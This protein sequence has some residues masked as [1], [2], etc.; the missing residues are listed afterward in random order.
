MFKCDGRYIGTPKDCGS[1]YRRMNKVFDETIEDIGAERI[2][3]KLFE[4]R[5]N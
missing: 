1:L 5:R 2:E 4:A 3:K